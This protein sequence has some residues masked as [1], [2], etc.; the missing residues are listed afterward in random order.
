MRLGVA[1]IRSTEDPWENFLQICAFVA[2]AEA[3]KVDL[4]CFPENALFRGRKTLMPPETVLSLNDE[5]QLIAESEFSR[6][7]QEAI[8]SWK[9][10]V[11]LGSVPEK[12]FDSRRPY[13]SHWVIRPKQP[14]VSYKKIHLFD[15]EGSAGT[16]RESDDM[17][18]GSDPV[19]VD[20]KEVR[21][22]LSI[23]YDLRFPELYR[24]LTLTEQARVLL[25]PAA[26]TLET[27]RAHWHALLR[28]RAIENLSF[29]AAAGQWGDHLN[30]KGQQ[31]YCYGHSL[32]ISP[33]G[34]VLAEGGE[35]GDSLL[36][37]DLNFDEQAMRRE[38]LPALRSAKLFKDAN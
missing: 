15:Y 22:G 4:V 14:I 24:R 13:N 3:Q 33:W 32:I 5:G 7:L 37:C 27:G 23:C 9:V 25:V 31:M 30:G 8:S 35:V 16:Y 26:F 19:A 28:A 17:S 11:S 36:I 21:T 2:E 18:P 29:V 1:Q 34:E 10:T 12:S 6:A 20:V 38:R